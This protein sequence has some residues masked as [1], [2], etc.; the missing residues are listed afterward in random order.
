L[1]DASYVEQSAGR[2]RVELGDERAERT[3]RSIAGYLRGA[4]PKE[5][6]SVLEDAQCAMIS[7]FVDRACWNFGYWNQHG[8]HRAIRGLRRGIPFN[9]DPRIAF[10]AVRVM[11]EAVCSFTTA[12]T[13][14]AAFYKEQPDKEA[15]RGQAEKEAEELFGFENQRSV[16]LGELKPGMLLARPIVTQDGR[17]VLKANLELTFDI[18][19]RLWQLAALRPLKGPAV[20]AQLR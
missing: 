15:E 16:S 1:E 5:D 9:F 4:A 3:V 19:W 18:I 8:A 13:F 6:A 7:E 2:I 14:R 10:P 17:V 12:Q 20:I 11:G